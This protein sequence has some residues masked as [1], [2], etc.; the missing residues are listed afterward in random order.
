[1][2]SSNF[3]CNWESFNFVLNKIDS[4]INYKDSMCN[5]YSTEYISESPYYCSKD[6]LQCVQNFTNIPGN[7]VIEY[8]FETKYS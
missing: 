2:A 7:K 3:P 6:V 1:M 5:L 8:M 4:I